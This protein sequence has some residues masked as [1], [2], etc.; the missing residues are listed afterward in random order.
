MELL[1][2]RE[3]SGTQHAAVELCSAG[4]GLGLATRLRRGCHLDDIEGSMSGKTRIRFGQGT[5]SQTLKMVEERDRPFRHAQ[6]GVAPVP[7]AVK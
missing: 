1:G 5:L 3:W 4:F 6:Q 7:L 2:E